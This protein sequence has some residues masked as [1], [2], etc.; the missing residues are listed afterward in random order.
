[1]S[2]S[3]VK[4]V[5]MPATHWAFVLERAKVREITPNAW[6]VRMVEQQMKGS[7]V[8]FQIGL[9]EIIKGEPKELPKPIARKGKIL[10]Y[11][12]QTGEPVV[13]WEKT[14]KSKSRLKGVWKAP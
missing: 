8:R 3:I 6:M 2:D 4:S 11:D 1:M 5:R 10:G 14:E 13:N 12:P 7:E 9:T